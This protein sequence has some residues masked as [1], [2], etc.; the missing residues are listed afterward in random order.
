MRR[1]GILLSA[2]VGFTGVANAAEPS[3]S[4]HPKAAWQVSK[5]A[6]QRCVLK[7]EFDN[8]FIVRISGSNAGQSNVDYLSIDFIQSVFSQ[9]QSY[10]VRLSVPGL[11][12][13]NINA[14]A[15]NSRI[16]QV[17]VRGHRDVMN[18]LE[19][20]GAFDLALDSNN[21]RFYMTGLSEGL[22]K[23]DSCTRGLTGRPALASVEALRKAALPA[24]VYEPMALR[25]KSNVVPI[26]EILP[27]AV[28][29]NIQE[30]DL[31]SPPFAGPKV[32]SDID[33]GT[34]KR[35]TNE[36][37]SYLERM[38]NNEYGGMNSSSSATVSLAD[39][40]VVSS[41]PSPSPSP[42]PPPPPPSLARAPVSAALPRLG[43][44][45]E[46][47]AARA[48]PPSSVATPLPV[49]S[50][51]QPPK[52]LR[53]TYNRERIKVQADFAADVDRRAAAAGNEPFAKS[54]DRISTGKKKAS[55]M[56]SVASS[57][58]TGGDTGQYMNEKV[59]KMSRKL[60][61]LE[62]KN[63]ALE[64]ELKDSYKATEDERLSISSDN[65]NLERATMRFNEAERQI[66]KLGRQLQRQR[67]A[68]ES[69]KQELEEMLFDPSVTEA[70]QIAEL[71]RMEAENEALKA[72]LRQFE[73]R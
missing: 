4:F 19:S 72:R 70:S 31:S 32:S 52:P 62:A 45:I 22:K 2:L 64:G 34:S 66:D 15:E 28:M 16:L 69:E 23:F 60:A 11:V 10:P 5:P 3:V 8:G 48:M 56:A 53:A 44:E 30:V 67:I 1:F 13:K 73:G 36:G 71:S 7:N 27:A 46:V 55:R 63:S 29:A 18:A 57:Y 40:I 59:S 47:T 39:D 6:A 35:P 68:H 12:S 21:F 24:P 38:R 9:G 41:S 54:Y 51:S 49:A 43:Q 26:T 42:P 61:T 58:G 17:G 14:L 37:R 33:L 20:T 65:W 50:V 25:R